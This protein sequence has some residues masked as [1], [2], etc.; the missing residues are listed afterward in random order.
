MAKVAVSSKKTD[1]PP[2]T[3]RVYCLRVIDDPNEMD[4]WVGH[5][6][7]GQE[8]F[9]ARRSAISCAETC[10][11]KKLFAYDYGIVPTKRSSGM[12]Q[13]SYAHAT[14]A[15]LLRGLR[16]EAV[17]DILDRIMQDVCKVSSDPTDIERAKDCNLVFAVGCYLFDKL[18]DFVSGKGYEILNVEEKFKGVILLK[19]PQGSGL[20]HEIPFQFQCDFVIHDPKTGSKYLWDTKVIGTSP[21]VYSELVK[22]YLQ[23]PLYLLWGRQVPELGPKLKGMFF[24][25]VSKPSIGRK[26][27]GKPGEQSIED[28]LQ[29]VNENLEGKGRHSDKAA[30]RQEQPSCRIVPC[31]PD[32]YQF[33]DVVRRM[34]QEAI[35]FAQGRNPTSHPAHDQ[36]GMG[37]S[38][39]AYLPICQFTDPHQW[40]QVIQESGLFTTSPDPLNSER[41][42]GSK[43]APVKTPKVVINNLYGFPDKV[44]ATDRSKLTNAYKKTKL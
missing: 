43:I 40:K 18:V 4:K 31:Y 41:L 1:S 6:P 36:C 9:V 29:E 13:S 23:A 42:Q 2:A 14:I 10:P 33:D 22:L 25:L 16:Y 12:D 15:L 17:I 44:K 39:C 27:L 3:P 32:K 7:K 21:D 24:G 38:T 5:A 30:K 20:I 28:Y 35:R 11:R 19:S 37:Y 26:A 8:E 34:R